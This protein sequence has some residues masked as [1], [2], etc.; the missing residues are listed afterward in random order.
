MLVTSGNYPVPTSIL[1][2]L[3]KS[4]PND[5]S[6]L[7]FVGDDEIVFIRNEIILEMKLFMIYI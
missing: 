6:T 5:F 4:E 2:D 1:L 7:L 3:V